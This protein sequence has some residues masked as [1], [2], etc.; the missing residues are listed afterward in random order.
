MDD[1]A[2]NNVIT[3]VPWRE[4]PILLVGGTHDHAACDFGRRVEPLLGTVGG[5]VI[6]VF[7]RFQS[8]VPGKR[9]VHTGVFGMTNLLGRAGDLSPSEHRDWREGN[10]WFNSAYPDPCDTNPDVYDEKLHPRA[11]AW[12][13]ADATHLLERV[14]R[15]LEILEAH[16]VPCTKVEAEDPGRIIYEDNVQIVVVPYEPADATSFHPSTPETKW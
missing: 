1:E 9:G 13:K 3:A 12:F 16:G 7:V 5:R 6:S 2:W 10:D 15:Y 14:P 4:E 8:P 11:T